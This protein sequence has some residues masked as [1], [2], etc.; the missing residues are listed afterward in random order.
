MRRPPLWGAH[1]GRAAH[2][3]EQGPRALETGVLLP[4]VRRPCQADLRVVWALV[5][6][7]R[8]VPPD[9]ERRDA[10]RE[11]ARIRDPALVFMRCDEA[12]FRILGVLG[13]FDGTQTVDDQLWTCIELLEVV[14]RGLPFENEAEVSSNAGGTL[15]EPSRPGLEGP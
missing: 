4:R 2:A 13:G 12:R 9:E 8:D 11:V 3:G 7:R 14:L 6:E 5:R 1:P 10:E 15:V